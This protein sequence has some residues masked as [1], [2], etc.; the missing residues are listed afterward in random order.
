MSNEIQNIRH[1][2]LI[3]GYLREISNRNDNTMITSIISLCYLYYVNQQAID[4]IDSFIEAKINELKGIL[5]TTKDDTLLL[6]LRHKWEVMDIVDKYYT[7]P[8]KTLNNAGCYI[9][10]E[11]DDK[12]IVK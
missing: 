9:N 1:E 3:L 12:N 10:N 11:P 7:N 4:T 2:M 8:N 6:L 5:N